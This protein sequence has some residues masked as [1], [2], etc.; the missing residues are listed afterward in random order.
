MCRLCHGDFERIGVFSCEQ[1]RRRTRRSRSVGHGCRAERR[2]VVALDRHP[3]GFAGRR[4]R[5][6]IGRDDQV[7]RLSVGFE[8]Q[9][10]G[11]DTQRRD[12]GLP[13]SLLFDRYR[14][15]AGV[16]AAHADRSGAPCIRFIGCRGD[17]DG[18]VTGTS[19][20]RA[21]R[22]AVG[23]FH[24]YRQPFARRF[25]FPFGGCRREVQNESSSLRI[26]DQRI[27]RD[28]QCRRRSV[29][30]LWIVME[31]SAV[32]ASSRDGADDA[33]K[34]LCESCLNGF[35]VHFRSFSN[36]NSENSFENDIK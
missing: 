26:E 6:G 25:D 24:F 28:A 16:V 14:D 22:T 15:G 21:V 2:V 5:G 32:A 23:R 27:G 3:C 31:R 9:R 13:E 33:E 4:P 18:K 35:R 12:V 10:G 19:S 7:E 29:G 36:K 34:A 11:F 20:E 17:T 1:N 8:R 30:R